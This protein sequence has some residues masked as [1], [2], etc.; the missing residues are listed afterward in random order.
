MRG[1]LGSIVAA[2]LF[3]MPLIGGCDR[4][5]SERETTVHKRDGTVR[6]DRETVKERPDGTRVYEKERDVDR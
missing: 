6:T 5:V 4:T 2:S 1:V 3:A